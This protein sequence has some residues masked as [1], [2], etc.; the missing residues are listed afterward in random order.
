[1]WYLSEGQPSIK[2]MAHSLQS[3]LSGMNLF[4]SHLNITFRRDPTNFRPRINKLES[5]KD[6]EQK[7]AGSY[8]YLDD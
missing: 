6:R 5:T 8:Y 4:L 3:L 1:M 7:A 2:C